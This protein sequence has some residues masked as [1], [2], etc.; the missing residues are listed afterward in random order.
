V[1]DHAV[2]RQ[3]RQF[4]MD[5]RPEELILEGLSRSDT[6]ELGKQQI[7]VARANGRCAVRRQLLISP[8]V[9]HSSAT[10]RATVR[11]NQGRFAAMG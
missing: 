9:T 10:G 3:A 4:V 7:A 1:F 6:A 8:S 11:S 2:R 5:G